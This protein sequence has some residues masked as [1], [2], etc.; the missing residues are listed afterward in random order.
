LFGPGASVLI[1]KVDDGEPDT[2]TVNE[3]DFI[4]F[5][6]YEVV[7]IN[8]FSIKLTLNVELLKIR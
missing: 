4:G 6:L 3:A 7:P 1:C 8:A 5:V 2:E